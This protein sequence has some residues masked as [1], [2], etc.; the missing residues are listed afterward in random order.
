MIIRILVM[1]SHEV[2]KLDCTKNWQNE[3]EHF[4][5]LIC[6]KYSWNGR[7]EKSSRISSRRVFETK[8]DR[9]PRY[10]K[11]AH[12]TNTAIARPSDLY[13][14]FRGIWSRRIYSQLTIT[15]PSQSTDSISK[16]SWHAQPRPKPFDMILGIRMEYRETFLLVPLHLLRHR[17]QECSILGT[18]VLR[19]IS[20]CKRVRRDPWLEMKSITETPFLHWDL[21][22]D[23]Q[24]KI[25]SYTWR[26]DIH[27]IIWPISKDFRSGNF[28]LVSSLHLQ[29]SHVGT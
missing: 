2:N 23:R 1:N 22:E 18:L 4:E 14:W 13:E 11:W 15:P 17:L 19:E 21:R 6:Q 16:P 27:R 8:V 12:F 29:H 10:C 25:L 20:L 26:K 9:K 5:K 28:T 24:P 7:I 3:K